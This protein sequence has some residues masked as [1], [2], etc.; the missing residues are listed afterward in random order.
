MPTRDFSPNFED[1]NAN[2]ILR[3][4]PLK[5]NMITYESKLD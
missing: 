3:N 1:P 4:F 2:K 5:R